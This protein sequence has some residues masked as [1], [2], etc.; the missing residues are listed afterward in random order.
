M[1]NREYHGMTNIPEYIVWEKMRHRCNNPNNRDYKN[2]G[3][4]GIK[5]CDQWN[6]SFEIFYN[7]MGQRPSN[8]HQIERINNDGNYEPKNCK[9]A[10]K[11]EQARNRRNNR[12]I[13]YKGQNK[14]LSEWSEILNISYSVL[15]A[16][17]DRYKWTIERSFETSTQEI[18][19]HKIEFNGEIHNISEWS[20]I[21]NIG[22]QTLIFR[23]NKGMSFE[24]AI[25]TPIKPSQGNLYT[26][27]GK[28][29][30]LNQWCRYYNIKRRTVASRLSKGMNLLEALTTPVIG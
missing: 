6:N 29:K 22:Y 10:T 16:R 14:T 23:L 28:T 1:K 20:K 19:N 26:L 8:K 27:N 2:Y 21:F 30:N 5:V 12:L 3:G 18:K 25:K 15:Q 17:I 24:E 4:R 11:K 7:D 13:E 9:W